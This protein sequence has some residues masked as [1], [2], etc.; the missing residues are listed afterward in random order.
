MSQIDDRQI[1]NAAYRLAHTMASLFRG[2][3]FIIVSR[4]LQSKDYDKP[5]RS[6]IFRIYP[7]YRCI[8]LQS[9]VILSSQGA[10]MPLQKTGGIN[11]RKYGKSNAA[12]Q[13]DDKGFYIILTICALAIVV[14]GYV[15]FFVP[16]SKEPDRKSTR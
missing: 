2:S 8:N 12:A 4:L 14:S 16:S 6:K 10:R 3:L 9:L 7:L 13:M 5:F 15:L 1:Q 11:M